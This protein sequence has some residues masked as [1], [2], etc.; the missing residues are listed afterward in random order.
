MAQ[1]D[2]KRVREL[3]DAEVK[4]LAVTL[5]DRAIT[6]CEEEV[7]RSGPDAAVRKTL[8]SEETRDHSAWRHGNMEPVLK[9]IAKVKAEVPDFY[10]KL[11]PERNRRGMVEIERVLRGRNNA[12][13]LVGVDHLGG[14]EGLLNLLKNSGYQPEQLYGVDRPEV[15]AAK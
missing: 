13:V 1:R 8:L 15:R 6:M 12:M 14:V 5:L 4:K 11:L 3:D 9:D 10:E 2:W 7:A